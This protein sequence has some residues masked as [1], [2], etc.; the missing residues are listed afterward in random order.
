MRGTTSRGQPARADPKGVDQPET[1]RSGGST[2]TASLR[3]RSTHRDRGDDPE[4]VHVYE[5]I[6]PNIWTFNGVFRARRCVGGAQRRPQG[7]Q[8]Q[9]RTRGRPGRRPA[10]RAQDLEHNRVIPSHVKLAV[11]RRERGSA[12][13]AGAPTTCTSTS[14]AVLQGRLVATAEN[15]NC[16]VPGTIWRIRAHR[17]ATNAVRVRRLPAPFARVMFDGDAPPFA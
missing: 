11:W 5:K 6:K 3:S 8:V 12:S 13:S 15:V 17:V 1:H 10:G 16:S 9:A 4:L 7:L 14:V 2:R